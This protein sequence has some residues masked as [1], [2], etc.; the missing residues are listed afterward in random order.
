MQQP[1]PLYQNRVVCHLLSERMLEGVLD[2]SHG[3]LLV[4]EFTQLQVV[5]R[6]I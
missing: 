1:A 4:N 2:V 3:G 6:A 5:Q